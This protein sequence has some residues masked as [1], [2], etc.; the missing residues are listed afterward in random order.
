MLGSRI[1][2]RA[3]AALAFAVLSLAFLARRVYI[4][5]LATTT[6]RLHFAHRHATAGIADLED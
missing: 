4:I 1:L 2:S 5:V 3:L 6:T